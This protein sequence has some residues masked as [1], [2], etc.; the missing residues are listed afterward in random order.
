MVVQIEVGLEL[1]VSVMLMSVI[2][3]VEGVSAETLAEESLAV[4][5]RWEG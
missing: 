2:V 5:V 1:E 4:V 3:V